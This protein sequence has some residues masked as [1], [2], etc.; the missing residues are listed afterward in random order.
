MKIENALNEFLK[1]VEVTF[2]KDPSTGRPRA[3]KPESQKDEEQ[4]RKD[5]F[6]E[7]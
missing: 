2:R 5:E 3:N 7:I 4:R 6:Y 1:E